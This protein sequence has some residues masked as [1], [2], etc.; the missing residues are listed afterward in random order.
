M[1]RRTRRSVP[2]TIRLEFNPKTGFYESQE[3]G[4]TYQLTFTQMNELKEYYRGSNGFTPTMLE[5]YNSLDRFKKKE[6]R[7]H[8]QQ[9][10]E[11]DFTPDPE[12]PE[13]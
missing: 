4:I 13:H 9:K 3:E 12:W 7:R 1:S 11:D 5:W 2:L 10:P 6:I 8:G